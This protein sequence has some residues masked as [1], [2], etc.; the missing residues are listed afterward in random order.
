[1]NLI[2][3]SDRGTEK[4]YVTQLNTLSDPFKSYTPS[5]LE[6]QGFFATEIQNDRRAFV[7]SL[8]KGSPSVLRHVL[9]LKSITMAQ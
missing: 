6:L 7:V 2:N 3:G 1:M 8:T 5:S 4:N 9:H